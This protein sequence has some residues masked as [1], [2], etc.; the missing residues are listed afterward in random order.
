MQ[1]RRPPAIFRSR[2]NLR[3][4]LTAS[5]LLTDA[6]LLQSARAEMPVKSEEFLCA[7]RAFWKRMPQNHNRPIIKR[8]SVFRKRMNHAVQWSTHCATRRNLQID[9]QMNRAPLIS[10]FFARAKQRRSVERP[11]LVVTPN[12]HSSAYTSHFRKRP[13]T[14]YFSISRTRIGAK[15]CATH[16]QIKNQAAPRAQ[17]YI[18]HGSCSPCIVGKPFPQSLTLRH[19]IQPASLPKS[20]MR[21]P[22]MNFRQPFQR[23]PSRRLADG[24]IRIIRLDASALR[25]INHAHRQPHRNQRKQNAQ[26]A[27]KQWK[28][29]V[30]SGN[31]FRYRR[32]W[33][34]LTQCHVG[35]RNR[36]LRNSHAL[37]QIAEID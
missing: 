19:R 10:R 34:L 25:R 28:G 3:E 15:K 8:R 37:M 22:R 30:I 13:R 35:S 24:H 18:E 32:Q 29:A 21:K 33:I 36:N 7:A 14:E 20:V 2:P 12:P 6:K 5:N 17:I 11:R 16:A 9:S 4:F 23:L 26:F 31:Q 27:L 1:M